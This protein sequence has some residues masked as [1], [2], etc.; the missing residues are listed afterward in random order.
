MDDNT[1]GRGFDR[2]T[3][4]RGLVRPAMH[5]VS[6][7]YANPAPPPRWRCDV[8]IEEH[9]RRQGEMAEKPEDK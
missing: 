6:L 9:A 5:G 4:V 7:L 2:A 1:W 3:S 8:S